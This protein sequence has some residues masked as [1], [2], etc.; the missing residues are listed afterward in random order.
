MNVLLT[1][2]TGFLGRHLKKKL[3]SLNYSVFISNTKIANLEKES[4]LHVYNEMKFDIIFHLAAITNSSD[5]SPSQQ[6]DE[7][8]NINGNIISYW[9]KHQ[10]DAKLI[11]FG[12]TASYAEGVIM[13]EENYFLKQPEEKYKL[14]SLSKR[15][16]LRDLHEIKD[17]NLDWLYL[18]SS[19]I[20]GPDFDLSDD[21]YLYDF[22]RNCYKSKVEDRSFVIWGSGENIRELIYIDDVIDRVLYTLRFNKEVINI[23][24]A[25]T[26]S[27]NEIVKEVCNEIC[28][29][30]SLVKRDLTKN[31]GMKK[32]CVDISKLD[33]LSNNYKFLN[34]SLKTGLKKTIKYY[35]K[36]LTKPK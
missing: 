28:Y 36:S 6:L 26:Y 16:M 34:T 33:E 19:T 35:K 27:I 29:D 30:F 10:K 11:C 23:G 12:T 13:K 22:I 20:Y 25:N 14:Y 7:N 18:I 2:A 8:N 24:N 1:G 31:T 5:V 21:R 15:K 17:Q 32:K 4:N 9:K 3:I